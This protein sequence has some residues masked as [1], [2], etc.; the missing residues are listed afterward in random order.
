MVF[1][2]AVVLLL[3]SSMSQKKAFISIFP[4]SSGTEKSHWGPDPVNRKGVPAQLFVY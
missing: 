1:R 4:L 2:D 3:T